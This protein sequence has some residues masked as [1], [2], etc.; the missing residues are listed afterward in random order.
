MRVRLARQL[1]GRFTKKTLIVGIVIACIVTALVVFLAVNAQSGEK[2]LQQKIER[3]YSTE[4][5]QF[6]HAM[7]VLLGPPVL[8]GN[9]YRV[10]VNGDVPADH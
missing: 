1:R 8:N 5:P 6:L 9:R 3:L 4:D 7:G 10:L 2:K